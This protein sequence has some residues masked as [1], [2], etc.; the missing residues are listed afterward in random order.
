[1]VVG[2]LG[3]SF[4]SDLAH[5]DQTSPDMEMPMWIVYLAIPCGSYL[6]S[7]RFLQ[8]AWHFSRSGE[9]PHHDAAHVEGVAEVAIVPVTAPIGV[10]R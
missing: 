8:V 2:T 1:G 4:V 9:L 10:G 3:V 7:F 6:M 5:T